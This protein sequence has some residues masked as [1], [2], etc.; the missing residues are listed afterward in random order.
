MNNT[1][2]KTRTLGIVIV[3]VAAVITGIYAATIQQASASPCSHLKATKGGK[4]ACSSVEQKATVDQQQSVNDDGSSD[5]SQTETASIDQ[6][7]TSTS[8]IG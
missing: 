6:S 8:T 3:L 2:T 7:A 5:V 1:T 4:I